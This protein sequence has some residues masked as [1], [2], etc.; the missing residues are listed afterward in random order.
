MLQSKTSFCHVNNLQA[1][2][3]PYFDLPK[4]APT[5]V[6]TKTQYEL[7][8]IA[9]GQYYH[10]G[11]EEG[12]IGRLDRNKNL[13]ALEKLEIQFNIDGLPL[14]KSSSDTFW[15]ILGSLNEDKPRT[16]FV[17]G[18]WVGTSKPNDAN[19]FLRQF[20]DEM[21]N[22][23]FDGINYGN[24]K[25]DVKIANIVCD[26]P[27][28]AFVK[29]IKGHTG[30]F[31]CDN[32]EVRGVY[33]NRRMTFPET[34]AVLRMD[35]RFDEM[36]NAEHH[37]GETCLKELNMGLVSNFPLDYM[38]LI[39]LGLVKKIILLWKSGPLNVRIGPNAM[40]VISNFILKVGKH[41]PREFCRKGRSLVDIDRWKATEC[42]TFLLYTGPVV[43]KGNISDVLYDSFMMLSVGVYILSSKE[44]C[45]DYCHYTEDLFKRF[46]N[47]F[48]ATYGADQ[49]I[50]NVQSLSHLPSHVRR[51]G[52]LDNFSSF[53]YENYLQTIK[54][55]IRKPNFPL[56][57]V[58]RR[59]TEQ[60]QIVKQC[61][62]I[63]VK[64]CKDHSTVTKKRHR[65]G[66]VPRNMTNCSQFEEIH[67]K[68][69]FLST[70]AGDNAIIANNCTYVIKNIITCN[71]HRY[72]VCQKFT[73]RASFFNYP[74]N[75]ELINIALVDGLERD[76]VCLKPSDVSKAVLLPYKDKFVSI[77]MIK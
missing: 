3:R 45:N 9:G 63:I 5:L 55:L 8:D 72:L 41:I 74:L 30:Y 58:I 12:I 73:S 1:Q 23:E 19:Q 6:L 44:L 32:C 14:F 21:K 18:L 43:L 10:F 65:H 76:L 16:P 29:K 42:R 7:K 37:H 64:Q 56:P 52:V 13:H 4:D 38:H 31:G 17:I 51:F 36:Q 69:L 26:T 34:D 60:S 62:K 24:R 70:K 46:I 22:I 27:D 53:P 59:L 15:P 25:I 28:R 33:E 49:I 11:I 47:H 39:C 20:V 66:P 77:P 2:L 61:K 54:S 48:G 75:S 35:V 68:D 57:Q 50:Y 40:R 67:L 71:Y